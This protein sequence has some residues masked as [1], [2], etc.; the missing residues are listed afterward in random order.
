MQKQV[1]STLLA[2]LVSGA[3][4]DFPGA[5]VFFG[6]VAPYLPLLLLGLSEGARPAVHAGL[7][8]ITV[9]MLMGGTQAGFN[10]VMFVVVPCSV[11]LHAL[12]RYR[13]DEHGRREWF[14]ALRA[15]A[16][17]SLLVAGVYMSI[18][19]MASY[20]YPDGA[21]ALLQKSLSMDY[22]QLEPPVAEIM[23]KLAHE[24]SFLIFAFAAW[25]WIF[26]TW[27]VTLLSQQLLAKQGRALRPTIAIMPLGVPH[28]LLALL[29]LCAGLVAFGNAN[30]SY[31]AK[32]VSLILFLPYFLSGMAYIHALSVQ[33]RPRMLWLFL[34]YII[35]VFI[36]WSLF[37]PIMAGLYF[38]V[39]EMLDKPK[40]IG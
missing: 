2:G 7:V 28:G 4:L 15:V 31:N 10:M 26:L 11:I 23:Q 13:L 22:S 40:K 24:W 18:A 32:V 9:A 37:L 12:L 21:K 1:A 29:F 25:L 39:T 14:P 3:L 17:L 36:Q 8:G 35:L 38:H 19:L 20:T 33:W 5:G 30:D 34:I 6:A 27:G 16:Y